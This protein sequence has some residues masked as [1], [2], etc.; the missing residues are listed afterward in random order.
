MPSPDGL[1]LDGPEFR[2]RNFLQ[3]KYEDKIA[4]LNTAHGTS[5]ASVDNALMP[6]LADD[7]AIMKANKA[8]IVREY[9]TRNYRIVWDYL[10]GQGRA[11][12][13]TIIF[14]VLNVLTALIVNPLAAY[15]LSRFQPR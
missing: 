13:N 10:S 11:F 3:Q 1:T 14:C 7:W 9:L 15:A 12:Q 6:I 4:V 5:Y 8:A 2:W